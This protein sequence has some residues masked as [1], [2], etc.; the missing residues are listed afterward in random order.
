MVDCWRWLIK[1]ASNDLFLN[2][3][4]IPFLKKKIKTIYKH[5]EVMDKFER[6]SV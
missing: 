3:L 1:A 6:E 5:F 4:N 2:L